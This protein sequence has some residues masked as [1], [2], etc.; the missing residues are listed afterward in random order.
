M[1]LWE[2]YEFIYIKHILY[3][4]AHLEEIK[5]FRE[6]MEKRNL[7][8]EEV[9]QAFFRV[10]KQEADVGEGMERGLRLQQ[11]GWFVHAHEGAILLLHEEPPILIDLR[12][13]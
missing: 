10:E 12:L 4:V 8:N 3:Q 1:M 5:W 7:A 2:C 11:V 13:Q 9:S 6:R